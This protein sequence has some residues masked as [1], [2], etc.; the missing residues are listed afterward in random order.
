MGAAE[1][2]RHVDWQKIGRA[3]SAV[4]PCLIGGGLALCAGGGKEATD[5]VWIS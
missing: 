3:E 5:A 2:K 4:L 1:L